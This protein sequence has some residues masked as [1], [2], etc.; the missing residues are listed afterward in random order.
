M[1]S[2]RRRVLL[3]LALFITSA[4]SAAEYSDLYIIPVAGHTRGAFGTSWRSDLV[5]HNIQSVPIAVEIVMVESGRAPSAEPVAVSA[6]AE[7]TLHL[8]PGETRM[9]SDVA[10]SLG[11]DITGALIV[12][13]DL[14]F[15]V[16][17]RT[18]ADRPA[19]RTL[20]QS[21]VAVGM[22][23]A[24]D[25]VNEVA[26]LPAL[27]GNAQQRS[28]VGLFVAASHAPLVVEVAVLSSAGATLASQL[29]TIEEPGFVHRQLSVPAVDH[30]AGSTAI[31]RILEGD[32][33]AVPYASTIDNVSA[34]AVF[35]SAEPISLRGG[36]TLAMLA[37]AVT[38]ASP[39]E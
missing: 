39:K 22:S 9:L 20:G 37:R 3:V 32:G 26:V 17:S 15:A 27:T 14:P 21:V 34:E 16:T 29:I 2:I 30:A 35:V 7:T 8:M 25:A 11:R 28:N 1:N 33:I 24:A 19:G 36:A 18:W 13:A 6:G 12:G 10:G 23:G 38:A 5:L 31:I 4:A